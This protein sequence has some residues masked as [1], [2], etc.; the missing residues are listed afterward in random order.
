MD[1]KLHTIVNVKTVYYTVTS[2]ML[3]IFT[4]T[5]IIGMGIFT[6]N[7]ILSIIVLPIAGV[8]VVFLRLLVDQSYTYDFGEDYTITDTQIR[9]GDK[10]YDRIQMNTLTVKIGG[11]NGMYSGSSR[12]NNIGIHNYVDMGF[13]NGEELNVRLYLENKEEMKAL[14]EFYRSYNQ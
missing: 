10:I 5:G 4:F 12:F 8:I 2:I 1:L 6:N 9:L 13:R 14:S 3:L 11:Y 7:I